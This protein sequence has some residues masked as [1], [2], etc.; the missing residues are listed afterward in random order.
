[1]QGTEG[2]PAYKARTKR[3]VYFVACDG[4]VKIGVANNVE[5]RIRELQVGCPHTLDLIGLAEGGRELEAAYHKRFRKLRV[6]GEWFRLA[7]PLTDEIMRFVRIGLGL[8]PEGDL[9]EHLMERLA[10]E[11]APKGS[12]HA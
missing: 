9:A 10:R 2:Q 6:A 12:S 1:V 5:K 4:F 7:P 11:D 3:F 8:P